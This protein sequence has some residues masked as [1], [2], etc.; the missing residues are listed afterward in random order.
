MLCPIPES[1]GYLLDLWGTGGAAGEYPVPLPTPLIPSPNAIRYMIRAYVLVAN[2]FVLARDLHHTTSWKESSPWT[3]TSGPE[4]A[5]SF[6]RESRWTMVSFTPLY[7]EW[8]A[9]VPLN[10]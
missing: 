7:S 9:T 3:S 5:S 4:G 8:R 2:P 6:S 1:N 10:R